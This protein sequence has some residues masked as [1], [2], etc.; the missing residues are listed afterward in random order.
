MFTGIKDNLEVGGTLVAGWVGAELRALPEETPAEGEG[1]VGRDHGRPVGV[2]T[3]DG[4]TCK[5]S[6]ICPHLGGVLKWND[7]ALSWDCP[8]HGSRFAADGEL[9]E[10]PAVTN[11][12]R[13]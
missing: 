12:S 13:L 5:V 11:L 1:A 8:L 9:L 10:G 7:A 6:A 4:Q 2:S 3:V